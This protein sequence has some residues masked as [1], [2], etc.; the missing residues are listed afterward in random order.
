MQLKLSK[1]LFFLF[2][3]ISF[4]ASLKIYAQT[5][6][7]NFVERFNLSSYTVFSPGSDVTVNI[8]SNSK[9]GN[10]FQFRLLEIT[11]PINFFSKIDKNSLRINFDIWGNNRQILLKYTKL[12]KQW[13][14]TVNTSSYFGSNNNLDVGKIDEPGTYILQAIKGNHVAYCG[15]V[16]T[17][18]AI[19]YKNS[20]RQVLAYVADSKTGDVIKEVKFSLFN[21]NKL[22]EKKDADN[23]GLALFSIK[24]NID[25]SDENALLVAQTKDETILSDPYFYFRLDAKPYTAYIY[26]NQPVYRPGQTVFYKAIIRERSGNNLVNVT[27][28]KFKVIIRTQKRKEIFSHEMETNEFGSISGSFKLSDD[29]ELGNYSVIVAENDQPYFGS[30]SVE[31]YKKPEYLVI[32]ATLKDHYAV[33]DTIIATIS[34][35]YYF[36]SP[37]TEG[38]VN[39]KVFRQ[40]YWRPWWLGSDFAWFYGAF[41]T[42]KILEHSANEL[43]TQQE[44]TLDRNG[45][46]VFHYKVDS[47]LNNDFS[48]TIEAEV[49]DNS[50]QT[51]SGSKDIYVT[52]GSFNISTSPGRY[53]VE[54]GRP[55]DLKITATDFT[56]KPVQTDFKV[57][58]NYPE[59]NSGNKKYFIPPSD[60]LQ[61]STDSSGKGVIT[62]LPRQL[63]PGSYN[64]LVIAHDEKGRKITAQGYFSIGAF[65]QSTFEGNRYGVEILTDKDSYLKGD[66]LTA[67]I[68]LS[69]P[70]TQL[71][72]SYE[73]ANFLGY[74]I[75]NVEGTSLEIKEKLTAD[76]APSFNISVT[77]M[78]NKQLY[79]SSKL[80]GVLD[81][82]KLLKISLKPS[83]KIFKPGE[84]ASYKILVTD[85]K[86]NPVKNADLSFGII[87]ESIYAIKQDNTPEIQDFFYAP[88]YSYM[89][90]YSSLQNNNYNGSSRRLL[91]TD[92][93]FID[94]KNLSEKG[95][96]DLSGKLISRPGFVSFEN[97]FV[98]L[99]GEK[100]FYK[101]KTD[102]LGNYNFENIADGTYDSYILLDN[103]ELLYKG[104]IDVTGKTFHDFDLGNFQNT[105]PTPPPQRFLG[106]RDFIEMNSGIQQTVVPQGIMFKGM[107]ETQLIQPQLRSNFVDALIWKA[108]VVTDE[109]G[110]ADVNFKMPD[111]L[112]TW[113][114]TVKGITANTEAG[115]Q[116]DKIISRKNLLIRIEAPRFFRQGDEVTVSTIIHNYLSDTKRVKISFA[117][118]N[119]KLVE[120]RIDRQGIGKNKKWEKRNSYEVPV[121]PLNWRA[122]VRIDWKVKVSEPSDSAAL[123]AEALTNEESDAVEI[124]I[125]IHPAGIKETD[126]VIADFSGEHSDKNIDF[127]IPEN[128][129]VRTAKFS[130]SVSPSLAGTILKALDDLVGYP[131]GCVEQTMS[132][133]LPSIIV[134]NTFK[135]INAPLKAETIKELPVVVE[136]GLKRLYGFQ[137]S[138]GGWGW[139]TND[140]TNPYMTAYVVYGMSLAKNAGYS[141]D[142]TLYNYGIESLTNQLKNYSNLDPTTT[143]FMLYVYSTAMTGKDF[144]HF[145]Y[146]KIINDLIP[147]DL[148]PYSLALLAVTLKNMNSQTLLN[149][150]LEKLKNSV[151]EEK[152]FAYWS[153]KEWHY[154]WQED[155]VQT[156]AFAVKALLKNNFDP[157]LVT[158]AVR[159]LLNQKQGFSWRSTQETAS[160]I[161]ALADY[162][163]STNELNPDFNV[164]V[165]LNNKKLF[166]KQFTKE[167]IF[168]DEPTIRINGLKEKLL[169]N[170]INKI[171]IKKSGA[172]KLY[173]SGVSEY[174][175]TDK[176]LSD[177]K[178]EIKVAREYFV[179][180]PQQ[181]DN[182]IIYSKEKFNGTVLSGDL[183]L[184][185]T[186]VETGENNLQYLILEDML[187][188]GFEAVKDENNFQIEGENNNRYYGRFGLRPWHWFYADKEYHDDKVSFFVTNATKSMDFSY[189]IR[190]EIPGDYNV[191]PAQCYLMY[192]PEI[193]GRSAPIKI[194]VNDK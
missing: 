134:A 38:K 52:R 47:T 164:S 126:P 20:G 23:E 170:G 32:V 107:N 167:N 128:S 55:I 115:Q 62:F 114:A 5:V 186:H 178:S 30:F 139:W 106:G 162:L 168:T 27:G 176:K 98:L 67:F 145:I 1:S 18:K 157:A 130:F 48:Y 92:K 105:V 86:G 75:Y 125:P 112:T 12:I 149:T 13:N 66:T 184:V 129:D 73:A 97:I 77:F 137:H 158:K 17:D 132:R 2:L 143:A 64:Y 159:W 84:K 43:I 80:V 148:N 136:A 124:K 144:D 8:F 100:N 11:D 194:K 44:G 99:N 51:V 53:F 152:S 15:I 156:T 57:I 29:A 40:R 37:V 127:T 117:P 108:D 89:P 160:V 90:V 14:A 192:Y 59:Q 36:G 104:K 95:N 31:E 26:T 76:Y 63:Y 147:K 46:F 173:F 175:S 166:D 88:K 60:T 24:E 22:L 116:E 6:D 177:Q 54:P 155:K 121:D 68:F 133:F 181:S 151:K 146:I 120:S 153:G 94:E 91:L 96:A 87:D 111:N 169:K 74:K 4:S 179:L 25:F 193:I 9:T 182:G 180:K 78:K 41:N 161:F 50:R 82:D 34:A 131:Y 70:H 83:K 102:T 141:V 16:V 3:F 19:I 61:G 85:Q 65:H 79:T 135:E 69:Q 150:V 109:N 28:K 138:D 188:S 58:V 172:G 171:T 101:I 119:I 187:P 56:N 39:I 154:S 42:R 72:V 49:T 140:Q 113:R 21:D 45:N 174:Y 142:S 35:K 185:K 103:A 81:K 191:S 10:N 110:I 71:L 118:K 189:I 165:Y 122:E 7:P 190:A 33:S 93:D 163:K 183:I 123:L